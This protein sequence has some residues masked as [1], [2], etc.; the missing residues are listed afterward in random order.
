ML[1]CGRGGRAKKDASENFRLSRHAFSPFKFLSYV[2]IVDLF[3]SQSRSSNF[4]VHD[5]CCTITIAS[6]KIHTVTLGHDV[7]KLE[8]CKFCQCINV[9]FPSIGGRT[10]FIPLKMESTL[11][12]VL[13][14]RLLHSHSPFAF[15]CM[16]A[17]MDAWQSSSVCRLLRYVLVSTLISLSL[18]RLDVSTTYYIIS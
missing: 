11:V 3:I 9:K 12:R 2:L 10:K 14:T 15:A 1:G 7:S 5:W 8:T 6:L 17:C 4:Y 16:H 13:L 18:S